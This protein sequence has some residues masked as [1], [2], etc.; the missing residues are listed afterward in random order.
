MGISPQRRET[1]TEFE[2]K[3]KFAP[4]RAPLEKKEARPQSGRVRV[5]RPD[6]RL[7]FGSGTAGRAGL[8]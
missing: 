2:E 6:G 1:I 8:I 4:N 5:G 7:E 3:E